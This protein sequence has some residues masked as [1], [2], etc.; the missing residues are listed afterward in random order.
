MTVCMLWSH[1]ED[2][3]NFLS[4]LFVNFI[5]ECKGSQLSKRNPLISNSDCL[6]PVV[7]YAVVCLCGH[8][9]FGFLLDVTSHLLTVVLF[10]SSNFP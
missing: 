5:F 4:A 2:V 3:V 7:V 10:P 9:I 8:L 6:F 1:G